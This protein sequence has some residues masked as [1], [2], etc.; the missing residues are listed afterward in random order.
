MKLPWQHGLYVGRYR[1]ATA[2][3]EIPWQHGLYVKNVLYIKTYCGRYRSA[4]V[5]SEIPA[6]IYDVVR[7]KRNHGFITDTD[8]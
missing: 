2:T 1:S 6:K 3:L 4:T 5:T 7:V 8:K